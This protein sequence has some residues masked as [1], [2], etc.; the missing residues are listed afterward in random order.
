MLTQWLPRSP[1]ARRAAIKLWRIFLRLHR[2]TLAKAVVVARRSDGRVLVVT[3]PSGEFQLPARQLD[4]WVAI[5]AQVDELLK[6]TLQQTSTASLVAVDG[7]PGR[8]GVTFIYSASVG[9]GHHETERWL[10]PSV[11]VSGLS[12]GDLRLLSLCGDTR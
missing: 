8:E 7:T 12:D 6:Q 2:A 1:A 3:S 10:D 9:S 11:T 5:P 4:P